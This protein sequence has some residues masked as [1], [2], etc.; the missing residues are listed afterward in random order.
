MVISKALVAFIDKLVFKKYWQ[1][2]TRNRSQ[3]ENIIN[4]PA[5][6]EGYG[7]GTKSRLIKAAKEAQ[8]MPELYCLTMEE[9]T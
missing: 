5:L 9:N 3:E 8:L 6:L 7:D 2:L 1:E 4:W